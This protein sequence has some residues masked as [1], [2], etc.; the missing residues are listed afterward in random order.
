MDEVFRIEF[1]IKFTYLIVKIV[2]GWF[3]GI[4]DFGDRNFGVLLLIFWLIKGILDSFWSRIESLKV[5]AFA[6]GFRIQFWRES[7][8]SNRY[9]WRYHKF[10]TPYQHKNLRKKWQKSYFRF[11]FSFIILIFIQ[12]LTKNSTQIKTQD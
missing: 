9:N 2:F 8:S 6:S 11:Q 10:K 1:Q 4:I 7:D 5:Q 3:F 12:D